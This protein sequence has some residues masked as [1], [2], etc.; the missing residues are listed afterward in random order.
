MSEGGVSRSLRR[1]G[2]SPSA[3][4]MEQVAQCQPRADFLILCHILLI[5]RQK[6]RTPALDKSDSDIG[7][8]VRVGCQV[9]NW[10]TW[11]QAGPL[12]QHLSL[13]V[14]CLSLAGWNSGDQGQ[15]TGD[16][17]KY[18]ETHE[19][20]G[21]CSSISCLLFLLSQQSNDYGYKVEKHPAKRARS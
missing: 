12:A 14:N 15:N 8:R 17:S 5:L 7:P 10:L 9:K 13:S 1:S 16:R 11:V 3:R 2:T 18:Y 20:M 21:P 19:T 4:S 6:N